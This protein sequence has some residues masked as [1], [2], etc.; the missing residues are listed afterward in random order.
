[1][2]HVGRNKFGTVSKCYVKVTGL[3]KE[4][5]AQR[6]SGLRERTG[7]FRERSGSF[8]P[9]CHGFLRSLGRTPLGS[10]VMDHRQAGQYERVT[11]LLLVRSSTLIALGTWHVPLL[12]R[13][14]DTVDGYYRVGVAENQQE[15]AT[16]CSG[17][18]PYWFADAIR[19]QFT[20]T[21]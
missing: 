13:K 7:D 2:R 4:A 1:M 17:G 20:Y 16:V 21:E 15:A 12:K 5:F 6:Y 18:D 14:K 3:V 19:G 10:T 9:P 8:D 11:I